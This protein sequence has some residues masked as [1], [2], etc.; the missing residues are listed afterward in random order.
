MKKVEKSLDPAGK[1]ASATDR[2]REL[3]IRYT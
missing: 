2:I 3:L 1:S